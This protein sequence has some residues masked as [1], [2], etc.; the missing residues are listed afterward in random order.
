MDQNKIF[1]ITMIVIGLSLSVL[2]LCEP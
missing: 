2:E 1:N